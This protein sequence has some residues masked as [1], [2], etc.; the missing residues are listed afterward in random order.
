MQI[1]AYKKRDLSNIL[2]GEQLQGMFGQ[3]QSEGINIYTL[4]NFQ[5]YWNVNQFK[6]ELR[7]MGL[8]DAWIVAFKDGQRVP[9]KEALPE[10]VK[11]KKR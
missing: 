6:K 5:N 1:G 10:V 9:I 4:G 7:A 8:K 2:E 11:G 3:E